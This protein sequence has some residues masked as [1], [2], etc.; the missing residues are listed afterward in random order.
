MKIYCTTYCNQGHLLNG[1]PVDHECY[2]LPDFF[3]QCE[4]DGHYDR[5]NE[6]LAIFSPLPVHK[7]VKSADG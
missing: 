1:I 5:A 6:L 7:G 3:I 4:I 2:V